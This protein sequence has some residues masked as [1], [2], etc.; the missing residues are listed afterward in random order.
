MLKWE[1]IGRLHPLILH[2]PIGLMFGLLL[3]EGLALVIDTKAR[4][5]KVCR[6]AYIAL[7]ALSSIAAAVTGY[8]LS[9]EGQRSGD[10][11]IRHKW[12]G[13][14]VAGLSLVVLILTTTRSHLLKARTQALY[15]LLAMVGLL[16]AITITGHLGGQLT[17]GPRFLATNAPP[18]LQAY[19]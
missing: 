17:H 11:L 8:I 3:I 13:V 7:L 1:F 5:W 19:M 18:M 16:V 10:I 14:A 15:R 2:L 4:A 9:L 6:G 12:F